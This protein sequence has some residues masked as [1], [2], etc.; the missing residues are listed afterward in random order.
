MK[1]YRVS[2]ESS[3]HN[4]VLEISGWIADTIGQLPSIETFDDKPKVQTGK[5]IRMKDGIT[6]ETRAM[7]ILTEK[8]AMNLEAMQNEF[9][10]IGIKPQS[11]SPTLS[12]LWREKKKLV[13][14]NDGRYQIKKA[15]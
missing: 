5:I 2:F 3:D 10:R 8:G 14:L 1:L 6:L 15:K 13:R 12:R 11:A 4:K 7:K 9:K